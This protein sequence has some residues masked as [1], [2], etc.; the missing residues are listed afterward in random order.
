M[1]DYLEFKFV[2]KEG[3][4]VVRWEEGYNH[5]Y[6]FKVFEEAFN[7]PHILTAIAE[8]PDDIVEILTN[9]QRIAYDRQRKCFVY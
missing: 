2:I 8:G 5:V 1:H 4:N 3:S 9:T 7:K 6:H